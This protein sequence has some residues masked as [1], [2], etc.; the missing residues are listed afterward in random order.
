MRN[1]PAYDECVVET[2]KTTRKSRPG[3]APAI[4]DTQLTRADLEKREDRRKRNARAAAAC[5]KKKEETM[6]K[7]RS[8]IDTLKEQQTKLERENQACV[9]HCSLDL[10]QIKFNSLNFDYWSLKQALRD[11]IKLTKMQIDVHQEFQSQSQPQ[12]PDYSGPFGL[13]DL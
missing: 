8:T 6:A 5:R 4:P 1:P 3:V 2:T 13:H 11:E 7:L 10:D 12:W 9:V